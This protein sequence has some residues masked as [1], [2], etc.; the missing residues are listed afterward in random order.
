MYGVAL[1]ALAILGGF[2]Y[3]RRRSPT[4]L[5]ATVWT[6]LGTVLAV[7]L[8]QPLGNAIHQPRPYVE[9]PGSLLL[10]ARTT[11]FSFPSDHA[12]MAGAVAAGMFLVSRRLGLVVATG[13]VLLAFARVYVGAHY[14]ADV[15]AGL[16]FGAAIVLIGWAVLRRPLVGLAAKARAGRIRWI[17]VAPDVG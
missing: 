17:L 8:N 13:A 7:G 14:P 1:F 9:H 4:S 11:D 12:V 16:V 15:A 6:G 3:S 10:V 5:A 2:L